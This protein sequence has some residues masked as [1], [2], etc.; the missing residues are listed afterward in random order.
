MAT[1]SQ[2]IVWTLL[3][4]GFD[5]VTGRLKASVLV[6]PRLTLAPSVSPK[7]LSK[8]P[9]WKHWPDVIKATQFTLSVDGGPAKPVTRTSQPEAKVWDALFPPATYVRPFVFTDLRGKVILSYP[10]MTVAA[11]IHA[12]YGQLAVGAE[13]EL[14]KTRDLAALINAARQTRT[15]KQ[16]LAALRAEAKA[17]Q[18]ASSAIRQP[19]AALDLLTAYHTPLEAELTQSYV[20]KGQDDPRESATWLTNKQ[21]A[22][23]KPGDFKTLIDFHQIVA[24]LAQYPDLNRMAGLVVSV[25]IDPGLIP[26]GVRTLQLGVSWPKA[27]GSV[28]T[29]PDVIQAVVARRQGQTFEPAP[30]SPAS[31]IAGRYLKLQNSGFGLV[32][33]DVD[34]GALKLKNLTTNVARDQPVDHDDESFEH[35]EPARAGAPSLRSAGLMLVQARRDLVIQTQFAQAG[36]RQDKLTGGQPLPPLYAEDVVRGYRID[37]LDDVTKTWRSLCSR[38][39]D[40]GFV[41]TGDTHTTEREEGMVRLAAASS[42]D[43]SNADILKIH[44]GLFAWRGWSLCAPEPGRVLQPDETV[45]EAN[46]TPPD[47]LPLRTHFTPTPKSLP[48]LRFGRAYAMRVRLVDLAGESADFTEANVQPA[49]AVSNIVFY[50]RHEPVEAPALALVKG[51]GGLEAPSDG[52]S[53]GRIAIRTFNDVPAKNTVPNKDRG[54]RHLLPPRVTHRFAEQH[55]VMDTAAGKLDPSLFATLSTLDEPLKEERI[56]RPGPAPEHKPVDTAY[57]VAAEGF[58]LPYLPD[59]L[60]AGV[61]I[62]VLG[63]E[64]VNPATIHRISFYGPVFDPLAKPGWPK[65]LPFIIVAA[66]NGAPDAAFDPVRRE[67]VVPLRKGERARVRISSL[68]PRPSLAQMAVSQMIL[69]QHPSATALTALRK[70]IEEGQHWMFTPWRTIELVHAVQKPLITPAFTVLTTSRKLGDTA[71]TPVYRTHLH[72]KST[73]RIDL[74]GAWSEPLDDPSSPDSKAGPVAREHRAHAY[75]TPISRTDAPGGTYT[76]PGLRHVFGDTRYRRVTYTLDATTRHREFMPEK[77]RE[78][79]ARL[80]VTSPPKR[81][82]VANAAPPPPPKVLYVVPTFGWTRQAS[83]S[84]TSSLRAGDGLRVYLDRPWFASGFGE[85]LAVVLPPAAQGARPPGPVMVNSPQIM[86]DGLY[87]PFVTQWGTDP[88]W[89]SG[90]IK[91]VAPDNGA[92]PLARW[93]API[94]F[95]GTGLPAIEGADLPATDFPVSGLFHPELP[96]GLDVAPH[97]VG[98]DAE[99]GLW[100]A[101]IVIRPPEN[102]YYPF[103]RLALARYHPVSV[104]GAHLSSVVLAEFQQLTPDRLAIVTREPNALR[105]HVAVYGAAAL[106]T[107]QGYPETGLFQVDTQVL[108]PGADPDLG[109]RTVIGPDFGAGQPGNPTPGFMAEAY[110]DQAPAPSSPQQSLARQLLAKEDFRGLMSRP[111]LVLALRPPLLFETDTNLPGTPPGGRRRILITERERYQISPET[112]GL[113]PH[114]PSNPTAER[115]VYA[116]ALEA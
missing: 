56:K 67:F 91:S 90:R 4:N 74:F 98:Y 60:A 54:R 8:F 24:S 13:D 18:P 33:M 100:Y 17:G 3:P 23:P 101:D 58:S 97:P 75:Q 31:P 43:G 92:F 22:L 29:E 107:A 109:W 34:G 110:A 47:G 69:D 111:D 50:R 12:L 2:R 51:T 71:A 5:P 28:Q 38:K 87:R 14:P 1:L 42:A 19:G 85:M 35:E 62:R 78:D 25:Q 68:I 83:G 105:A 94:T 39:V 103:V 48:R 49:E 66:E 32:Q 10:V 41:N 108:D 73:A 95:D 65:G 80:K 52:E 27:G 30:R 84:Q 113:D 15:P 86:V 40:F 46:E 115:I 63:A 59:P 76:S 64:G 77:I 114:I 106:D 96:Q 45:A 6:S 55:G 53:M 70:R 81:T 44:E 36:G 7:A 37:V 16:V 93:H 102:V 112:V 61:A 57:A 72:A 82:W 88:I 79:E 116:E 21:V 89:A 11:G 99:R 9:D 104:D 26:D 20:K